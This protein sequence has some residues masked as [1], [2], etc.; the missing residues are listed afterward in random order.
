MILNYIDTTLNKIDRKSVDLIF[1]GVGGGLVLPSENY[2]SNMLIRVRGYSNIGEKEVLIYE[3]MLAIDCGSYWPMAMEEAGYD[4]N[5]VNAF[6]VSH[7]HGDHAGGFERVGLDSYFSTYPFGQNLKTI[8]GNTVILEDLWCKTL[9]GGLET[10][11]GKTNTLETFFNPFYIA[12]NSAFYWEGMKFELVQTV[13]VVDNRRISETFG[14]MFRA[15]N[16]KKI[17]ITGD[18]QFAP[19]ALHTYY[20]M[21]DLI[22][23]DCELA[24]YVGS[25]HAQYH[26]L[27]SLKKEVRNKMWLYHYTLKG[28]NLPEEQA[29]EDGFLGFVKKGQVFNLD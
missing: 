12:P 24:E 8:F 20:D 9:S 3:N 23:H 16:K 22:F 4:F 2:H 26:E 5:K 19:H 21:A 13:H 1:L 18:T 25:I 15:P 29:A 6:F 27:C 11:Q 17:F 28:K 14:L 10:L 7:L